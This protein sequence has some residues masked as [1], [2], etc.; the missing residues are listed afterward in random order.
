MKYFFKVQKYKICLC[1]GSIIFWIEGVVIDRY[2]IGKEN[3]FKLK[4]ICDIYVAEFHF[5]SFQDQ[6]SNKYGKNYPL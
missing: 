4:K 3:D 2:K 5:L 1:R 6:L